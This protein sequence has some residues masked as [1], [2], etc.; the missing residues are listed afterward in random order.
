MKEPLEINHQIVY[1]HPNNALGASMNLLSFGYLQFNRISFI[2]KRDKIK[3][4][5]E[6]FSEENA[7]DPYKIAEFGIDQLMN[8]IRLTITFENL[9]KA[10]LLLNHKLI[11]KLSKVE[12][13]KLYKEQFKRPIDLFDDLK[14]HQWSV[15][16]KLNLNPPQLNNQ[17]KGIE[18]FTLGMRELNSA[19]YQTLFKID[20]K[21]INIC[22]PYFEYRNNL[23]LY[24]GETFSLYPEFY[25]D[26]LLLINFVNSHLVRIHND[27]ITKLDKG[28]EYKL[29][30]IEN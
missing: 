25:E 10:L 13:P 22:K 18:K 12:F 3:I 4:L 30:I 23:H 29:N 17:I 11:H 28:E 2:E 9:M 1:H 14:N 15:N 16:D 26:I 6:N 5:C 24:M 19:N 21:V 7:P 20:N 27:I 8:S